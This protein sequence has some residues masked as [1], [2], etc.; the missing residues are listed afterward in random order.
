MP[1]FNAN[2]IVL[3]NSAVIT[4]TLGAT[5]YVLTMLEEATLSYT[6]GGR[7]AVMDSVGGVLL[8]PLEGGQNPSEIEL[9]AKYCGTGDA[10]DLIRQLIGET[11]GGNAKKTFTFTVWEAADPAAVT[12]NTTAWASTF[13]VEGGITVEDRGPNESSRISLRMRSSTAWPAF[14][15]MVARP[16]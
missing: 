8:A 3:A 16:T 10:D 13:V 15:S 7:G 1:V 2:R 6:I 4:F 5:V 14:A 11:A 9:S 12:G